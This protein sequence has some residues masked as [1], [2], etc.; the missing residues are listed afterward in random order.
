MNTRKFSKYKA[1]Y[2]ILNKS[3]IY[4]KTQIKAGLNTKKIINELEKLI[5]K[6]L[7]QVYKKSQKG[8]SLQPCIS[9]NN[10]VSHD[11]TDQKI[12]MTL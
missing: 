5:I 4:A 3:I 11:R 6:D 10:N 1:L 12:S 2:T 9:I 8:L 7:Q